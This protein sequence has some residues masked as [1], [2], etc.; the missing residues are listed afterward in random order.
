M[1][2]K[3]CPGCGKF[4]I[5]LAT[6][7]ILGYPPTYAMRWRCACGRVEEAGAEPDEADTDRFLRLWRMANR[8]DIEPRGG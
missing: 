4:M 8:I 5:R 1:Q 2:T 3:P 7:Q 6:G